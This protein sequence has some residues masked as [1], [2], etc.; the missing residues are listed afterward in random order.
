MTVIDY[1]FA[2]SFPNSYLEDIAPMGLYLEMRPPGKKLNFNEAVRVKLCSDKVR[3]LLRRNTRE[4]EL[5]L[6]GHRQALNKG[7]TR[8]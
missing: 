4:L 7:H 5:S 2:S 3:V 1:I 8:N 6:T